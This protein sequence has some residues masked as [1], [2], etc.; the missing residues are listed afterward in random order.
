[1]KKLTTIFGAILFASLLLTSCGSGADEKKKKDSKSEKVI[2]I[3]ENA[4]NDK[5]VSETKKDIDSTND[6]YIFKDMACNDAACKCNECYYKF[7]S[8]DGKELII[9]E[10]DEKSTSIK[11]HETI[12]HNDEGGWVEVIPNK[13]YVNKK[14]KITF[15]ETKCL[16]DG[17]EPIKNYKKL[18]TI[19]LIK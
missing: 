1:M 14:F 5:K 10:I 8:D 2:T 12:E 4:S 6:V 7:I 3:A 18:T 13:K 15:S 19:K 9:N 11:L 17:V 16:C